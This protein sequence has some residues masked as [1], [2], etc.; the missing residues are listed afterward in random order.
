MPQIVLG[1][2][3][4]TYDYA[5]RAE[6]LGVGRW[7]N[8]NACPR[9]S[10]SELTPIMEDVILTNHEKYAAKARIASEKSKK[11]G[12]GRENAASTIIELLQNKGSEAK[13]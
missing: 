10:V 5:N 12:I 6:L 8:K 11:R 2:W 4:D 7:G 1:V 9:W 13:R 3:A